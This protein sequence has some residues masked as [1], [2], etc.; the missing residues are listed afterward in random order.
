MWGLI[1]VLMPVIYLLSPPVV[2]GLL[3][4]SVALY[5]SPEV[6]RIADTIYD[7]A[8]RC[9]Q[10]SE[11]LSKIHDWEWK[12]M[13]YDPSDVPYLELELFDRPHEK[14][15]QRRPRIKSFHHR[16]AASF[17]VHCV[18]MAM[19]HRSPVAKSYR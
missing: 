5:D 2:Y 1:V 11:W 13:G 10:N 7:L 16:A 8:W 17:H 12:A 4:K 19:E 15:F 14:R 6:I 9:G 3:Y 18:E